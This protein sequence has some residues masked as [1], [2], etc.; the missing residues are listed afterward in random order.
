MLRIHFKRWNFFKETWNSADLVLVTLSVISTWILPFTSR[1]SATDLYVLSST[2]RL[3][4]IL[5]VGRLIR[6][7]I[8]FPDLWSIIS[9]FVEAVKTLFWVS[10]FLLFIIYIAAVFVTVEIGQNPELYD[11]YRYVSGG[12]D[13][14]EYFGTVGKSMLTLFQILTLDDWSG[15]IARHVMSNQPAMS[16]FFILFILLTSFGIMNVIT[17]IIVERTLATAKQN[18]ERFQRNQERERSRVLSHLREI[19]EFADKDG[20]GSLTVEEFR[21]A[22]RQPD[23][24]RKL[25]LIEL[26]VADAEELFTILDHDGSGELSVDEFIG[27]CVRLKGVAKSKDLLSVQ[28]SVQALAE[29]LETAELQLLQLEEYAAQMDLKMQLMIDEATDPSSSP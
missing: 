2:I 18:Q 13:Y 10:L 3:L 17:G 4:R 26:P 22:I 15:G 12:W 28:V 7:L 14:K 19:F 21:T 20:N 16:I 11:S 6:L 29:R 23:V 8:G 24:E 5:T 9:G 25:R 27:G 1:G